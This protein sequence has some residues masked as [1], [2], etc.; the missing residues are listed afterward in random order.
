MLIVFLIVLIIILIGVFYIW[1][2]Y[3]KMIASR[4]NVDNSYANVET[5]LKRRRDLIPNLV[6]TVKGYAAHENETF[7]QVTE[8]RAKATSAAE[9][10]NVH[11]QAQSE[12][13]LGVAL[14]RLIV[15]AENYPELKASEN[16][17]QLQTEL[18]NTENKIAVNRQ[19]YNDVVNRY[20]TLIQMFPASI[21]AEMFHFKAKDFFQT[22]EEEEIAP[23]VEF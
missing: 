22:T 2:T 1:K 5:Q 4:N 11:K 15:V 7:A 19:V 3:N 21:V 8:A 18:S 10:G 20:N 6:E 14:G 16:F 9:Q 12:G 13:I 23:T 17:Q